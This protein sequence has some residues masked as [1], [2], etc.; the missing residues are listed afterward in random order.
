MAAVDTGDDQETDLVDEIGLKEGAIDMTA[1][2]QKQSADAE[3]LAELVHGVDEINGRASGHDVGDSSVAKHHEVVRWSLFTD[4]AD[5][6]VA[7]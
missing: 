1:T 2:F 4:N 5:E 3:V 7:I 6:V